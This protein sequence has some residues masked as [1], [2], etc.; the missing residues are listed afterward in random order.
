M[1]TIKIKKTILLFCWLLFIA[2]DSQAQFGTPVL[3]GNSANPGFITRWDP[4]SFPPYIDNSV[5][6]DN[7]AFIGIGTGN[8]SLLNRVTVNGNMSVGS[9]Y[10]TQPA[11]TDGMIIEGTVG[12]GT[13]TPNSSSKLHVSG[14]ILADGTGSTPT[15]GAGTRMMWIPDKAA[16][17][18]G[19]VS[20]AGAGY[21]NAGFIGDYSFA[22]GLN[23]QASGIYS[24]AIGQGAMAIGSNCIANGL[25]ARAIGNS[26]IVI[27]HTSTT[28][29]L[30]SVAIGD[31]NSVMGVTSNYSVILGSGNMIEERESFI[32]GN[33]NRIDGSHSVAIGFANTMFHNNS[34]QNVQHSY[35]MGMMNKIQSDYSV[36]IGYYG[37][38]DIYTGGFIFSDLQG[39]INPVPLKNTANNQFMSRASGGYVFNTDPAMDPAAAINFSGT[40]GNVGIGVAP[41]TKLHISG[42]AVL[43]QGTIPSTPVNPVL[44]TGIRM[45]WIPDFGGAFRTGTVTGTQWDVIGSNSFAAGNNNEAS[46]DFSVALGQGTTAD[47]SNSAAFG[48]NAK[49]NGF[50]GGFV[51]S[52]NAGGSTVQNTASN[53]FMSRASGGYVFN[54]DPALS[55]S[56]SVHIA[57]ING[58]VGI[59]GVPSTKLHVKNGTV[60]AEGTIPPTPV[61]PVTGAGTRMAWVPDF[62]GAFRSG[63]VTGTQW[64]VIGSNSFA[65]GNNTEASGNYSVALGQG[66]TADASNSTALG[67]NAK[68]NGFGG[69]FVF[70]DNAGGSTV[71]NTVNNQFMSRATGGYVFNA[72]PALSTG[73]SVHIAG[74]NGNV[75]IGGV[76]STKLHVKGGA[77]LAEG[78]VSAIPVNPVTGAGNRMAW[79]PDFGGAFRAGTVTGT[80]WDIIG[81]SSFAAGHNSKASGNYSVAMGIG[82]EADAANSIALG[83]NAK[84]N[85][86]AGGFVFS[87]NAGGATVQNTLPN[88][89]MSR[90]SGGY[91]F[92]SDPA[93]TTPNTMV[94]KDGKLGLGTIAPVNKLNVAGRTVIGSASYVNTPVTAPANALMVQD[95]IGVFTATMR[96]NTKLDVWSN[97]LHAGYFSSN[98]TNSGTHVVHSVFEDPNPVYISNPAPGFV[99]TNPVAVYGSAISDYEFGYGGYFT[100]G[101]IGAA[102]ICNGTYGMTIFNYGTGLYGE[103]KGRQSNTGVHGFTNTNGSGEFAPVS[104]VGV[105]GDASGNY[106]LNIG[107][108]GSAS[109]TTNANNYAIYGTA[110]AAPGSYAGYFAG[111]VTRTGTDNFTSDRKFKENIQSYENAMEKIQL[112]NPSTYNFKSDEQYAHMNFSQGKRFGFIAQELEQVFPELVSDIVHPP[113]FEDGKLIRE[114]IPYKGVDYVS[115]IPVLVAAIKE[116]QKQIEEMKAGGVASATVP[117]TE[118]E[119]LNSRIDDLNSQIAEL[120][121]ELSRICDNP[122]VTG[123]AAPKTEGS[124]GST[125]NLSTQKAALFQ[126]I[127]NPMSAS[128]VIPY[129]LPVD[130]KD[131]FIVVT[132]ETGV[133]KFRTILAE[134]GNAQITVN[135]LN[136]SQGVYYYSL[137]ISNKIIDTRK[138]VVVKN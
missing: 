21:W 124:F 88:Q 100:G 52:D 73:A 81:T 10:I 80:Q 122:C 62:G 12:I 116:Q 119:K 118:T 22:A 134:K 24:Y 103:A 72:D 65:A 41:S 53:Q 1:K 67:T 20:G 6:F 26:S 106:G 108:R 49:S 93:I 107:V 89:F 125:E 83:S 109:G 94:F 105:R 38:T 98:V 112:L 34:S 33:G 37:E 85:G 132:T 39:G 78:T 87:D 135:G 120:K 110:L 92:H 43:A 74:I 64:D 3:E 130:A 126:N 86:N 9:G 5:I 29:G 47:A 57:G 79:I 117:N 69:G 15:A 59:G 71:Q 60:L 4:S 66:T 70:S 111:N 54:T 25:D 101:K 32:V 19:G 133:E 90:A 61:N 40:Y 137:I 114:A 27:G 104:N 84:S 13:F 35:A 42:G 99:P 91:V 2:I 14:T 51:F 44:G 121:G 30:G 77:V 97:D 136:L 17:R 102:G 11:P 7:G 31:N 129:Y 123:S 95:G 56:A 58:N 113:V 8:I 16:F 28:E 68:S 50:G 36:A 48:T 76:P 63:T 138:M 128:A 96:P 55:T 18:A 131:A 45:A 75:G 115:L 82:S 127:P 23:T 46:G